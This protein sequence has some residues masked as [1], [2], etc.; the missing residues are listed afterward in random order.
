LDATCVLPPRRSI[1]A[2]HPHSDAARLWLM[3]S[4]TFSCQHDM[5]IPPELWSKIFSFVGAGV[6]DRD[7]AKVFSDLL[8]VNKAWKVRL[9]WLCLMFE[10][11]M[12]HRAS[13]R[14]LC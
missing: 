2:P 11:F 10:V 12:Y 6:E 7:R 5:T 3:P 14:G 1:V 4:L 9:Y 13:S 8:L